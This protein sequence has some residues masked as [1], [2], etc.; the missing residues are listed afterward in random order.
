MI[1]TMLRRGAMLAGASALALSW[2]PVAWAD[3]PPPPGAH[4]ID[5]YPVAEGHYRT[6][7][8]D[9]GWKYFITPDGRSCGIGP[10][11]G[12]VGCDAVPMAAPPGTNQTVVRPGSAAEYRHSDTETFTRDVDVLPAGHRLSNMGVSCGVGHQGT[13]TCNGT[14][15]HGFTISNVYG[16]L[17]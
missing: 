17:W 14:V 7:V 8:E 13:V 6:G 5:S 9:Y 10:N 2:A 12:P 11:G 16:V 3:S 1:Q 4:D 15:H